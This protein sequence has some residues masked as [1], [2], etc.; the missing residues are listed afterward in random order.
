M[1]LAGKAASL[2]IDTFPVVYFDALLSY[3]IR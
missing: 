3:K 2:T 1:R